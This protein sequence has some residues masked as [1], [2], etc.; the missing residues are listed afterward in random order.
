MSSQLNTYREISTLG[1]SQIELI[2]QVYDG[3]IAELTSAQEFYRNRKFA[4]G[5]KHLEKA[6]KMVTHLYTTLDNEAG[7]AIAVNLGKLYAWVISKLHEVQATKD[8]ARFDEC[9]KIMSNLR[10][11]WAALQKGTVTVKTPPTGVPEEVSRVEIVG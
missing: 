7:G 6:E 9:L 11:G 2:L 8:L 3:V 1:N 5:Y 4:G 10:E